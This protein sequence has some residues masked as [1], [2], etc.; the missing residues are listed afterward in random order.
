[1]IS[2]LL[3]VPF[4][5]SSLNEEAGKVFME[6]YQRYFK[7]AKI[8]TSVHATP[9]LILHSEASED[10]N[11][12]NSDKLDV[13]CLKYNEK[14]NPHIGFNGSNTESILDYNLLRHSKSVN[15]KSSLK[16]DY[17]FPKGGGNQMGLN[18][19]DSNLDF[20]SKSYQ[21]PSINSLPF[22]S[23]SNTL[24]NW[25]NQNN[26]S[27]F[28]TSGVGSSNNNTNSGDYFNNCSNINQF[29]LPIQTPKSKKEEIKKWLSRI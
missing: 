19:R 23:R 13:N 25:E 24:C 22:I 8:Y 10:F 5:E 9:K 2:C 7:I 12:I 17:N 20:D 21:K 4:P 15:I 27:N 6:D 1:V 16:G 26:L 14:I 18:R 28:G 3:I 11:M 29:I